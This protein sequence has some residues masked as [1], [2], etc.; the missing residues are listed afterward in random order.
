MTGRLGE[1]EHRRQA[2]VGPL[3]QGAPLLAGLGN[4]RRELNVGA[5][6]VNEVTE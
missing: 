6:D 4:Q 1:I 3:G 2:G 5:D